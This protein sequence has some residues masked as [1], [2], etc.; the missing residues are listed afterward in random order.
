MYMYGRFK[1]YADASHL[2]V[3][4]TATNRLLKRVFLADGFNA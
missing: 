3:V 1:N 4:G 2:V